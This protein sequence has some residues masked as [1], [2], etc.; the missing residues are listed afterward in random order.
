VV[1][2]GAASVASMVASE[3]RRLGQDKKSLIV[4]DVES[5]RSGFF[6]LGHRGASA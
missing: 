4:D 1:K 3:F 6:G 2:R 5:V